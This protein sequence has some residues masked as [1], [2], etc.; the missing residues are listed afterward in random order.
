ME[1]IIKYA[2]QNIHL[3]PWIVAIC[4]LLAGLNLPFSIDVILALCA[5]IAANL[6][7]KL[8]LPLYMT[9]LISSILSAWIAY[10]LGR[11][12]SHK[13]QQIPL[14]KKV[15]TPK[16]VDQMNIYYS[17]FGPWIYILG[18]FIPFG[19]RNAIFMTSGMTKVKFL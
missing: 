14:I 18:R 9:F 19:I 2:L 17:K 13:V 1:T 15:V 8:T 10:S 3:A 12:V 4:V 16:R 11:F 5:F 6:S 7:P